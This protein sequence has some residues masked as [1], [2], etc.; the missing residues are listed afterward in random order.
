MTDARKWLTIFGALIVQATIWGFGLSTFTLWAAPWIKTFGASHGAIMAAIMLTQIAAGLMSPLAGDLAE[1]ISLRLLM[2]GG[3]LLFG[4]SLCVVAVASTMWQ[5]SA[6]Y[7]LPIAAGMVVTGPLVGQILAV[8][9]FQPQPGLAI[10]VVTLGLSVGGFAMPPIAAAVLAHHDWRT[11]LLILACVMTAFLVPLILA[12]VRDVLVATHPH[13]DE[14]AAPTLSSGAILS[15]RVFWG[16][17]LATAFLVIFFNA[18]YY[19]LGPWMSDMGNSGDRTALL[20]S[21]VAIAA[22]FGIAGFGA[23]ADRMDARLLLLI[24]LVCNGGGMIVAATGPFYGELLV[25]LPL[26][27][28]ATGGSIPLLAA[29]MAQRFGAA[30]F[31]RANGLSLLFAMMAIA[32]AL[33]AGI[34]RDVLGS[35]PAAF[36]V[37]LLALLPCLVGFALLGASRPRPAVSPRAI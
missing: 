11:S 4:A 7:A 15:D 24:V 35:Y 19:N 2:V 13:P 29:I 1:R 28:F 5:I 6:L 36:R 10:G 33:F 3:S 12:T 14:V 27:G 31:A 16:A 20:I 21:L 8:R 17:V 18:I 32:G 22:A 23:L 37:M 34:G 26:M 25:I 30:N 9:L